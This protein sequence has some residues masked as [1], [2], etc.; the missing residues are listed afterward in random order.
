MISDFLEKIKI[1]KL[2]SIQLCLPSFTYYEQKKY[3]N[4]ILENLKRIVM[5]KKEKVLETFACGSDMI[6]LRIISDILLNLKSLQNL[7]IGF[8]FQ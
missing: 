7:K 6:D 5:E 1:P 3:Y 4:S 8:K 2:K